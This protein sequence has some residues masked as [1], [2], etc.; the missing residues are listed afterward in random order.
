MPIAIIGASG[1][2]NLFYNTIIMQLTCKYKKEHINTYYFTGSLLISHKVLG[3]VFLQS[4][5][6]EMYGHYDASHLVAIKGFGNLHMNH[7]RH[8]II[9]KI[10]IKYFTDLLQYR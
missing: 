9:Y 5:F 10:K 8:L 7:E 2:F 3:V 1:I 6:T 4:F